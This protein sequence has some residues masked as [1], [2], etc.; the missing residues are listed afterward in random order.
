MTDSSTFENRR[1]LIIDDNQS[2]HRDFRKILEAPAGDVGAETKALEVELFGEADNPQPSRTQFTLDSAYQGKEGLEKVRRAMASNKPYAMTFLDVRMPPGWDG[3]ETAEQLWKVDPDLLI[4]I[5]TA[6]SDYSW[7]SMVK[8]L[9]HT[10]KL[11]ILKKPFD[12]MEVSQLAL[13][14][15][16]KWR[17]ARTSRLRLDELESLVQARTQSLK[18]EIDQRRRTEVELAQAKA[19]AETANQAKSEFLANMSHEIRTPMNGIFGMCQLLKD[20]NELHPDLVDLVNIL[21]SSGEVLL[22]LINDILDF[23]KIEANKLTLEKAFFSLEEL[24]GDTV[25]LFAAQVEDKQLELISI[26]DLVD[27]ETFIG[28][29]IRIRQ[30]LQNLLSNAIKFTKSGEVVVRASSRSSTN[31]HRVVSIQVKDTGIGISPEAQELLFKPFTQADSSITRRYGG[32]GLGLTI[33]HRLVQLMGGTIDMRSEPGAGTTFDIEIPLERASLSLP[34]Q[35]NEIARKKLASRRM[36]IVDDNRTNRRFLSRLLDSWSIQHI[37]A[38]CAESAL[39]AVEQSLATNER[40]DL[41]LTDYHMPDKDGVSFA[42][43]VK[44]RFG[45]KAPPS[46]LLTS[47]Y[48]RPE[49]ELLEA[50]GIAGCLFK[51]L[52]K[53][54]LL[55]SILSVFDLHKNPDDNA[56]LPA[57]LRKSEDDILPRLRVLVAED[58]KVN[59][60]VARLILGKLGCKVEIAADGEEA[61][62]AFNRYSYDL[63]FM[64]CQMPRI[65]G[66]EATRTIREIERENG[67]KR[68]PIIAMT[69]GALKFKELCQ[70]AGMDHFISKPVQR[71]ELLAIL[72]N[73]T[74][75]KLPS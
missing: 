64:D 72:K 8:R 29:P 62:T 60:Q 56:E 42:K 2:I 9:G 44:K 23:S 3:I 43:D 58:N 12:P 57:R 20:A 41:I 55:E 1:I 5:C 21:N 4:V 75:A 52:R 38:V 19:A 10:D 35:S 59:Q 27:G 63:I 11:L 69:A 33:C 61:I 47:N 24:I 67:L 13:S 36:L 40:L 37:E 26:V 17:L 51:P 66:F 46:L 32:T 15:T 74:S 28:D 50:A 70:Q 34:R 65:D 68:I 14:I 39:E 16:E 18:D 25:Q 22:A 53:Q 6:Y 54:H 48:K 30:V 7:E 31:H 71:K 45:D 49:P 73:V